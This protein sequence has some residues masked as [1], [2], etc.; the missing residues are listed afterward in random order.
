MGISA[1]HGRTMRPESIRT[2]KMPHLFRQHAPEISG[3]NL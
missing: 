2:T 1:L 3:Q